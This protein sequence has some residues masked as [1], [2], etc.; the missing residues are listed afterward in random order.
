MR[1]ALISTFALVGCAAIA[2][3]EPI[4]NGERSAESATTT[5]STSREERAPSEDRSSGRQPTPDDDDD[6]SG[7]ELACE[8]SSDCKGGA[9]CCIQSDGLTR[10]VENAS[11]CAVACR[12]DADDCRP[13]V[14]GATSCQPTPNGGPRPA[15]AGI[16]WCAPTK[17]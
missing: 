15:K 6:D 12:L 17:Q 7:P 16:G 2:D 13:S 10:C 5:K 3:L 14:F 4:D 1:A 11:A 9:L 8:S